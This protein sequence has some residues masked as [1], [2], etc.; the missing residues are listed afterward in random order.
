[1]SGRADRFGGWVG[2]LR[3]LFSPMPSRPIFELR[4]GSPSS[5]RLALNKNASLFL[6][7]IKPQ[8]GLLLAC[9]LSS[10]AC[11]SKS[12]TPSA[13]E[14][15][16]LGA[17]AVGNVENGLRLYQSRCAMCHGK[18]GASDGPMSSALSPRPKAF[19]NPVWQQQVNDTF[20]KQIILLGGEA[21][22]RSAAMP[23]NGDLSAEDLA[24]VVKA[25]R[26]F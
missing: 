13:A 6:G 14:S 24:S 9:L 4:A 12:S 20:L 19:N 10:F 7:L 16:T 1:M 15:A 5:S 3:C 11:K 18:A 2:L 23:A 17:P 25:I 26:S 22:Q 8:S 21:N